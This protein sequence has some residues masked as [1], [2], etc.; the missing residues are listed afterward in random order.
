MVVQNR[1]VKILSLQEVEALYDQ[2]KE[3]MV[4]AYLKLQ[5]QIVDLMTRVAALEARVNQNS[6]NSDKPPSSEGYAKPRPQSQRKKTGRRPGGQRGH[7]GTTL[8]RV[9]V[10]DHVVEHWPMC[11]EHCEAELS[12]AHAHGYEVRQ[13]HDL[14][15]VKLETT[16]HRAMRVQCRWCGHSTQAVFPANVQA[17]VQYGSGVMAFGVY[18]TAYQMLP[19]ER[20]CQMLEDLFGRSISGGTIMN[21]ISG[22]ARRLAPTQALIKQAIRGSAVVH[23][24]ETGLRMA[25]KLHWLHSAGTERL[26]YYHV[27]P[28]RAGQA[29]ERVGILSDFLGTA[30]HDALPS[31]LRQDIQ[32]ALCNAH[33]LR[34]LTGLQEQTRQRWPAQL[35]GVLIQ[36]KDTVAKAVARGADHLRS[37]VLARL[38]HDFDRCVNRAL[39]ANPRPKHSPN[40][41]GRPRASP[42]RNLAERL[43]HHKDS[44]LRFLYDFQ[45]PFD[46]NLAE[47]DLRMS[48]VKQK[49]SGC[50]RSLEGAR[51]FATIRGYL[52]TA[53]KQGYAAFAALRAF[54]DDRPLQLVLG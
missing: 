40:Q 26:T 8:E 13:V 15:P 42:A 7:S 19:I 52:S 44:V 47:R 14:P 37:D 25:G 36:M 54:L 53:R 23:V 31:Y 21:W 39:Q 22:C 10:A 5:E 18:A 11:C 12:Q 43:R 24:D 17:R 49:V 3:A 20:T 46:N 27:D 50:F 45:V 30:V 16:D 33:L 1:E 4:G 29:F 32:H 51:A 41:R 34:E 35:K 2:G 48:K 38:E 6:H 9:E 28:N